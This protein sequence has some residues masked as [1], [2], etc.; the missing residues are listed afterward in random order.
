MR[1]PTL[2]ERAVGVLQLGD[3]DLGFALAADVDERHLPADRDDG[4]FDGLAAPE[5]LR[6]DRRLEHCCKVFLRL[7]H[8]GS[9]SCLPTRGIS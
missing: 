6:L 1:S 3:L 4:A 5:P 9:S 7:S 2:T 8:H